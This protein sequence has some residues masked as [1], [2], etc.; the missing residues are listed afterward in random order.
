M[1]SQRASALV[2]LLSMV[3]VLSGCSSPN[4]SGTGASVAPTTVVADLA[5]PGCTTAVAAAPALA[6]VATSPISVPHQPFDVI[7]SSNG[8]WSFVTADRLAVISNLSFPPVVRYEVSVRGHPL[9]E[10]ITHDGRYLITADGSGALVLAVSTLEDSG[11]RPVVGNLPT[12][13]AGAV[14]VAVSPDDRFVFLSLENSNEIAVLNLAKALAHGFGPQDLVGMVPLGNTPVGLA[15][16][17]NG[18]WLYA[19]NEGKSGASTRGQGTLSVIDLSKA[20][21][22][23]EDAVVATVTAGCSPVRVTVSHQGTVWVTA[24]GS[25]ALLGYSAALLVSHPSRALVADVQVGEAPI[26]LALVN[27]DTRIV[28]AN[29]NRFSAP[30]A[31]SGLTVVDT[32]AALRGKPAVLGSIPTGN[33][34]REVAV[35]GDLLLVTDYSSNQVQAVELSTLP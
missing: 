3:A 17:T 32:Q 26:G 33:F 8:E 28:V 22:D 12:M 21:R 11:P 9:G 19:T 27:G 15:I 4:T 25:D 20:E 16:S 6:Q 7:S 2:V 30:G 24:R 18:H 31:T 1:A 10:A 13:G 5:T 23:P 35:Q 34:P 29:S 14:E